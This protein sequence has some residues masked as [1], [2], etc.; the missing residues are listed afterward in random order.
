M[1]LTA[2]NVH[3]LFVDNLFNKEEDKSNGVTVEGIRMT[4]TFHPE[5]LQKNAADITAMLHELPVPFFSSDTGWSFLYMCEDK[6]GDQ[7]TGQ[8]A[9]AEELLCMGLAL[10]KI[11]YTGP[12]ETWHDLPGGMPYFI[13]TQ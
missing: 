6:R 12:R 8:H 2:N 3:K 11:T 10:G 1:Q 9:I 5:R 4:V 7:W 13:I